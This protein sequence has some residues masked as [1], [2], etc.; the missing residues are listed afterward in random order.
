MYLSKTDFIEYLRCPKSLWLKKHES[1]EYPEKKEDLF[2]ER[3]AI[4]GYEVER[5][6]QSLFPEGKM[7]ETG[8][9]GEAYTRK[10]IESGATVLFQPTFR[11]ESGMR[12]I[13]D[14]LEKTDKGWNLYEV[15]SGT[16]I[17]KDEKHNHIKDAIFQMITLEQCGLNIDRIF[18]VHL[19]SKYVFTGLINPKRLLS[20]I[21]ITKKARGLEVETL[22]EVECALALLKQK[23]ID[24]SFCGCRHKT[25][26]NWCGAFEYFNPDISE[27]SVHS[28]AGIRASKL[29]RL[30]ADSIKDLK[31]VPNREDLSLAQLNQ[32]QSF[33][34]KAPVID[35]NRVIEMLS[36]I[37]HPI[38]FIDYES[39]AFGVPRL[40]GTSPYE[41]ILFQYSLDI[42]SE[43]GT[44]SH[45]EYLADKLMDEREFVEQLQ[46]DIGE[47]GSVIVW[48]KSFEGG[49][50]KK[51]AKKYPEY[52][53][54]LNE[55][56]KR[57]FDLRDVFKN[58]YIDHRFDGSSSIKK[59]LPVVCPEFSYSDLEIQ[60]GTQAMNAFVEMVEDDDVEKK[61]KIRRDL[62]SYCALDSFAMVQIYNF[63]QKE[64][65]S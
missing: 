44:I 5:Q 26:S 54:F 29:N 27:D 53:E 41:M 6:A 1:D 32:A 55:K 52:K 64:V 15:K 56:N 18:I 50:N 23:K 46:R 58:S 4:E 51:L 59:V 49:Q 61:E 47:K 39:I 12:V 36:T 10:A 42:L 21:D 17:K 20:F 24:K 2:L 7:M 62:L 16:G 14:I 43:D 33:K 25:R 30:L 11:T 34:R 22:G 60:D 9:G 13:A 63:L 8:E 3:L 37:E 35:R 48:H 65:C 19:N 38:H 40:Y 28:L 57:I 31:D 45:K